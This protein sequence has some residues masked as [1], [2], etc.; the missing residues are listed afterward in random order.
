[1]TV[2]ATGY[3]DVTGF[4][5]RTVMPPGSV[6]ELEVLHPDYLQTKLNDWSAWLNARLAKRYDTPFG[7]PPPVIVILWLTALVTPEAYG[8][9]GWQPSSESD[10]ASILDPATRALAEVKEAADSEKGLF[11]LPL[12]SDTTTNG[13]SR[14][15]PLA[16]SETSPYR[17]FDLQLESAA[18]ED[19]S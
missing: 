10:R 9:L 7:D 16:Y 15:G 1:M 5:L 3:L 4:S 8:K 6:D 2:A 14:G 11:E 18:S 19:Y 12:R 13:I 17:G